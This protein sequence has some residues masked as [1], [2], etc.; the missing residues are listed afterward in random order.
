MF[1]YK[2]G[3]ITNTGPNFTQIQVCPNNVCFK[4][5]WTNHSSDTLLRFVQVFFETDVISPIFWPILRCGHM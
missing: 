5:T 3:S 1:V 2:F 4:K